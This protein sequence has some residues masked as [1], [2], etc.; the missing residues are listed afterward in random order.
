MRSGHYD[1]VSEVSYSAFSQKARADYLL[2]AKSRNMKGVL[3]SVLNKREK[4]LSFGLVDSSRFVELMASRFDRR[5]NVDLHDHVLYDNVDLVVGTSD[6]IL[7]AKMPVD[8]VDFGLNV[9]VDKQKHLLIGQNYL[10]SLSMTDS[11][12][13]VVV[14]VSK[15]APLSDRESDRQMEKD[16][17]HR[18]RVTGFESL[19]ENDSP[20][21]DFGLE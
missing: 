9:F 11:D 13:N 20:D 16:L 21:K 10:L 14:R 6:K 4:V 2:F 1:V 17:K 5:I 7:R 19:L 12:Q 15:I 8:D 18:R 3:H